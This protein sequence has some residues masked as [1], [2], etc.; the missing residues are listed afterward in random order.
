MIVV[1]LVLLIACA[2]IANLLLA[3]AAKRRQEIAIRLALGARRFRLIRQLLTE[4]MLLALLGGGLGWLLAWWL[5]D[6]L[7]VWSPGRGTRL[8]ADLKLDWRVFCFT[9]AVALFTGILFG[10]APALRATRVD[11]NSALKENTRGARGSLSLLGKSLVVGQV[12]AALLLL[13]GAGL[14]VRTL[15]NLQSVELGFN[16]ENLLYFRVD[17]RTKG[18][19]SEQI[20]P[21]CQQLI[22]RIEAL[23]GVRSTTISEFTLLSGSRPKRPG[24]SAGAH[25][26][27]SRQRA[28]SAEGEVELPGD[29]G[30]SAAGRPG[31]Y[32]AGRRT[33][34]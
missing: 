16:A 12:A 9:A 18:Y 23:P 25:I 22:E 34:S 7:L 13:V 28:F 31:A 2:N 15:H 26:G 3:R 8:D 33:F 21:L 19:K 1:G 32:C 10:L 5:K 27:R 30:N 6:L 29:D 20:V 11:L 14:F 17:P 24:A 4:S